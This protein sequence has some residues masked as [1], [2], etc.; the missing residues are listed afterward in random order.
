M[1][2]IKHLIIMAGILF[3]LT[4]TAQSI[5]FEQQ[6]YKS[7]GVYDT[8]EHSPFRTGKLQGNVGIIANPHTETDEILG[9]APIHQPKSWLF[10]VLDSLLTP[11]EHASIFN[12]R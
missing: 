6:D 9:A 8:W 3:P 11:S 4:T 2:T 1:K 10:N 12:N 5:G 7:I